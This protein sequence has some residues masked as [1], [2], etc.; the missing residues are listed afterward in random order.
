[1][2]KLLWGKGGKQKGPGSSGIRTAGSLLFLVFCVLGSSS[3]GPD[4]V[5]RPFG[6][7]RIETPA[8]EYQE[9]QEPCPFSFEYPEYAV[10]VQDSSDTSTIRKC[11]Y[12]LVVPRMRATVHLT[13][14]SVNGDLKKYL[15]DSHQL[16]YTH[17]IKASEIDTRS[18]TY[19][20]SDAY[21]MIYSLK[22][23]VATPIQFHVTDSN[24]HFLRGSLYFHARPNADSL[25]PVV[26][27]LRKDIDHLLK[28]LKWDEKG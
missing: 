21:G 12:D 15:E 3:C 17:H 28:T 27:F 7:L 9:Y 26:D 25:E 11:W 6:H 4:P 13:Y 23:N 2:G 22:G 14:R 10:L 24:E 8:H 20:S 18:F 16:V 1:M 5:P 19:D